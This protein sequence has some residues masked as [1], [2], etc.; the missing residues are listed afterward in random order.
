VSQQGRPRLQ[1]PAAAF[2]PRVQLARVVWATALEADGVA[3]GDPG[4]SGFWQTAAGEG[5][6]E[7]IVVTARPDQR[8]DVEL[9]LVADW[10]TPPLHEVSA[11]IRTA[12][13]E[14]AEA[15]GSGECLGD[16]SISFTD[17]QE[18]RSLR[19]PLGEAG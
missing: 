10:P 12:V 14:A 1:A 17:L 11:A 13:S 8:F 3:G 16:L 2:S 5:V 15:A 19:D 18:P 4:P 6:L 9:R 7:G